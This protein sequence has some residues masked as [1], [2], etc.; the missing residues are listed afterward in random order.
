MRAWRALCSEWNESEVRPPIKPG[1]GKL[2]SQNGREP[3]A[4][5]TG[6][7][8]TRALEADNVHPSSEAQYFS[9]PWA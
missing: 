9:G 5:A 2:P 7:R 8:R 1:R 4:L 6:S 3:I